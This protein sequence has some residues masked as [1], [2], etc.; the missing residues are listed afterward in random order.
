MPKSSSIRIAAIT[1]CRSDFGLV[2]PIIQALGSFSTAE[3]LLFV[4]GNHTLRRFGSTIN[5]VKKSFSITGIWDVFPEVSTPENLA[6]SLG[7]LGAASAKD[8]SKH[9][10]DALLIVGDRTEMLP[11]AQSAAILGIP[12]AHVGGGETTK[13]AIDENIRGCLTSLSKWHF[14]SLPSFRNKVRRMGI[15]SENI[16]ITGETALDTLLSQ[17]DATSDELRD[18]LGFCPDENT[19]VLV[20][21][22]ETLS[23]DLGLKGLRETLSVLDS[24]PGKIVV[25]YPNSD[26][27]SDF[28]ISELERF[29]R[30]SSKRKV[31]PSLGSKNWT[32]LLKRAG[33]II[34]NSSSAIIEAPSFKLPG[35]NIGSRQSGRYKPKN[36]VDAAPFRSDIKEA[37]ARATSKNFRESLKK[38]KNPYGDGKSGRRIAEILLKVLSGERLEQ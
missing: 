28:I 25:T 10:P 15:E 16:F 18:F 38:L 11:P 22:P 7:K 26:A 3:V 30:N 20:Y 12:I 2:Q 1:G 23:T 13:G 27:G 4:T 35:V 5:Q 33:A 9:K 32:A 29:C 14:V 37:L 34:G 24:W 6:V 31:I 19:L 8:F 21:H 36:V 17:P